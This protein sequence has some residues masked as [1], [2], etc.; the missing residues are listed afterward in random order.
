VRPESVEEALA[1]MLGD[2]DPSSL[3][4]E[5]RAR[6]EARARQMLAEPQQVPMMRVMSHQNL[7]VVRVEEFNRYERNRYSRPF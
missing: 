6:L 5:M 3:E 2:T 1:A 4:P 7:P